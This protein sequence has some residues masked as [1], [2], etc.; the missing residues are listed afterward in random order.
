MKTI[1]SWDMAKDSGFKTPDLIHSLISAYTRE[2]G[3]QFTKIMRD[4]K[5]MYMLTQEDV[6]ELREIGSLMSDCSGLFSGAP[7]KKPPSQYV[8]DII[9]AIKARE[10]F[11]PDRISYPISL[12]YL[13]ETV[14]VTGTFNVWAQSAMRR[15]GITDY[16]VGETKVVRLYKNTR[17]VPGVFVTEEKAADILS[18]YEDRIKNSDLSFSVSISDGTKELLRRLK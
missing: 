6:A 5:V 15:Y 17:E 13:Y 18:D 4:R 2:T 14:S 12:Y 11:V 3:V 9:E 7:T 8:L 1:T 16:I 10:E